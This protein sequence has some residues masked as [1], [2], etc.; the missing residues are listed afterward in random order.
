MVCALW[1]LSVTVN[2]MELSVSSAWLAVMT[3]RGRP[4]SSMIVAMDS[5]S[6]SVAPEGLRNETVNVSSDSLMVSSS[7]VTVKVALVALAAMV[8]M[9]SLIAV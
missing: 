4:S 2:S 9:L 3:N 5:S 6:M 7:S 8:S 1:W